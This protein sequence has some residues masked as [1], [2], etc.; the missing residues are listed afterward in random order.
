MNDEI[1]D[2]ILSLEQIRNQNRQ[3]NAE[4][5]QMKEEL[6]KLQLKTNRENETLKQH[7]KV[8]D[9]EIQEIKSEW[10]IDLNSKVSDRREKKKL[11]LKS[12]REKSNENESLLNEIR[13]IEHE[14]LRLRMIQQQIP[15]IPTGRKTKS[16][17]TKPKKSKA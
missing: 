17:K 5:M 9:K 14:I 4:N 10:D 6:R 2:L 13:S 15:K 16:K 7:K 8:V 1:N 12:I 11:L 3:I